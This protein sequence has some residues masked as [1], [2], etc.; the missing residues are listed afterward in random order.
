MGD[1]TFIKGYRDNE[2]LRNSYNQLASDIFGIHFEKWFKLGFWT[3]KYEPYSFVDG[4]KVIANVSINKIN[5][6]ISGEKKSAVQIG[7]VMTHPDY[8]GKGLSADLMEKVL[9]DVQGVDLIYLFANNTV[10]DYYPR[11]GFHSVEEH[12]PELRLN[13]K[14]KGI[15]LEKLDAHKEEVLNFIYQSAKSRTPGSDTFS[16]LETAEL[17]MFYCAY[18]FP[19]DIYYWS[20]KEIIFLMKTEGDTLH[21]FDVISQRELSIEEV[22]AEIASPDIKTVYFHFTV[23]SESSDITTTHYKG[24]EVLFVKTANSLVLPENFKHPVT[25]Q[26]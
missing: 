12:Q 14:G 11:F 13:G 17:L 18:V 15:P 1:F 23:P 9:E 19:D 7:T 24:D 6:V 10:L 20:E 3:N 4:S 16:T 21:V 2:V 25:S 8:R 26:A 5:M 22:A